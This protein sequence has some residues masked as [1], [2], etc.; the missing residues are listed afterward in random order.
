M[1]Q[2]VGALKVVGWNPLVNCGCTMLQWLDIVQTFLW[3]SSHFDTKNYT[4]RPGIFF[5]SD[6][7]RHFV[8]EY[9]KQFRTIQHIKPLYSLEFFSSDF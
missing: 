4:W 1:G 6:F 2:G 3:I 7:V 8:P 5:L 9:L